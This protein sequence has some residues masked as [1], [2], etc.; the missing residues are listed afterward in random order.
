M[1]EYMTRVMVGPNDME[2]DFYWCASATLDMQENGVT[3]V[4]LD[5]LCT[6]NGRAYEAGHHPVVTIDPITVERIKI[7]EDEKP[8]HLALGTWEYCRDCGEYEAG[9]EE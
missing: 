4:H 6:V 9:E 5:D 7:D 2:A 1:S 3:V 8:C